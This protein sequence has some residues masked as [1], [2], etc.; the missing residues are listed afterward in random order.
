[1]NRIREYI[2][3]NPAQWQFDRNNPDQIIVRAG[4]VGAGFVRAGFKPAPTKPAPTDAG[5]CDT[6]VKMMRGVF[7]KIKGE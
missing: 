7:N 2:V 5:W 1:M 4:I 3:N 6:G